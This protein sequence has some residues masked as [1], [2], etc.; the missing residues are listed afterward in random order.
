MGTFRD[1]P[2]RKKI[3]AASFTLWVRYDD[4]GQDAIR[5]DR[6]FFDR[7]WRFVGKSSLVNRLLPG[8]GDMPLLTYP[9]T[10]VPELTGAE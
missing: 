7:T 10:W 2:N 1:H 4:S 8:P 5:C 9:G 6:V 3:F